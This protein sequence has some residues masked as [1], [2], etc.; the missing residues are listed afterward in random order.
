MTSTLYNANETIKKDDLL[1]KFH[2]NEVI[3]PPYL[4]YRNAQPAFLFA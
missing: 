1:T 3:D 4:Q 2:N